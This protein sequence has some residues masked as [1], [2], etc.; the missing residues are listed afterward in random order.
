MNYIYIRNGFGNKIFDIIIGL[1][2]KFKTKKKLCGIFSTSH[3]KS[4]NIFDIFPLLKNKFFILYKN[5]LKNIK[6]FNCNKDY[7]MIK[8][9]NTNEDV[10]INDNFNCYRHVFKLY[11]E[12]PIEMKKYF[13]INKTLINLNI[14]NL[15]KNNKN[16]CAIHIRYRDKLKISMNKNTQY[17]Y[18]IYNPKYYIKMINIFLKKN[19]KIY[20]LTDDPIIVNKFILNEFKNNQNVELLDV[21]WINSFYVLKNS[22]Y[23]VLSLSTFSM[24]AALFNKNLKRVYV[25]ERPNEIKYTEM[26]EEHI[27]KDVN[28]IKFKKKKYI[29]NYDIKLMKKMQQYKWDFIDNK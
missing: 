14:K 26:P 12:L 9:F 15:V 19:I 21:D 4:D 18:L 29:L 7:N 8:N 23:L 11:N 28:W 3:H 27:L 17:D 2:I 20:V 22:S 16:Y 13:K 25:I 5:K 1:Y 10:L 6:I 24:L